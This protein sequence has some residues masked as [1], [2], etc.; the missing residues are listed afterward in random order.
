MSSILLIIGGLAITLGV[1]L[2]Y[3][4][5]IRALR[6]SRSS[7]NYITRR[8]NRLRAQIA[9]ST[10]GVLAAAGVGLVIAAPSLEFELPSFALFNTKTP[11]ASPQFTTTP[12]PPPTPETNPPGLIL[13]A[14]PANSPTPSRT[15]LPS[16]PLAVEALFK[17]VV[18]PQ[19]D[20]EIKDLKFSTRIENGL[21]AVIRTDFSNPITR[22]YV[23]FTYDGLTEGVQWTALWYRESVLQY[24]ETKTWAETSKGFD[25]SVWAQTADQWQPGNYEVQLFIGTKW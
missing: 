6:R 14:T 8:Q 13:T 5:G 25:S 16:I 1:I 2:S 23:F 4:I 9:F 19:S 3:L 11:L 10:L 20:A 7:P 18:T 21:P 12:P 15:P 22:M 24:Y 17:S